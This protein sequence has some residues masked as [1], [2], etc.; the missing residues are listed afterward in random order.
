MRICIVYCAMEWCFVSTT[1]TC[2]GV[3]GSGLCL[4]SKFPITYVRSH[5]YTVHTGVFESFNRRYPG[6]GEVFAGKGIACCRL[7]TPIGHVKV[8]NTHVG[9]LHRTY[10]RYSH[11]GV[12]GMTMW[13]KL[14]PGYCVYS[15]TCL[16]QP[17][18]S[19]FLLTFIESWLLYRGR[20]QCY[21]AIW[22]QGSWLF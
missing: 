3:V 19:Q 13:W 22:D 1:H 10:M 4:F 14:K 7:K 20:L 6:Q 11:L 15:G 9:V 21:S 18:V 12:G 16:R 5:P 17:P 8:Y 2:S